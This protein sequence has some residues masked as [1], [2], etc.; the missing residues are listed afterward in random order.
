MRNA[1]SAEQDACMRG[2]V[3]PVERQSFGPHGPM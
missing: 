3:G 1:S 2:E